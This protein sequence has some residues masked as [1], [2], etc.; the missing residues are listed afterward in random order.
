MANTCSN[1]LWPLKE[2]KNTQ[3]D[4]SG[5][6]T[7][8]MVPFL[9]PWS[10]LSGLLARAKGASQVN[11]RSAISLLSTALNKQWLKPE[12]HGE[13]SPSWALG[14]SLWFSQISSWDC[15]KATSPPRV[16]SSHNSNK[17][18]KKEQKSSRCCCLCQWK[19]ILDGFWQG[20][21]HLTDQNWATSPRPARCRGRDHS[22]GT[23]CVGSDQSLA[24][25]KEG[26]LHLS[27]KDC[28]K[29]SLRQQVLIPGT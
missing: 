2:P 12:R 7:G 15:K 3:R 8:P 5:I 24:S 10:S 4:D 17:A 22:R 11:S 9:H 28:W 19:Q 14:Q 1:V 23:G 29:M 25:E 16:V 13:T 26:L 6:Q 27:K 21:L 18:E 20:A